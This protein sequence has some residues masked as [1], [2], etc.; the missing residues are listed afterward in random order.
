MPM[1]ASADP[2]PPAREIFLDALERVAA[3]RP[4]FLEC[5]C[6]GRPGVRREVEELLRAHGQ[7]GNFLESPA[8]APRAS[9]TT[10]DISTSM[11][12]GM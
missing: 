9:Q 5:A 2:P 11:L 1:P 7:T 6:A 10:I 8:L 12:G 3:E 4:A